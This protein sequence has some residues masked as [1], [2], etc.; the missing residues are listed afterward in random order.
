MGFTPLKNSNGSLNASAVLELTTAVGAVYWNRRDAAATLLGIVGG[1][2]VR[3]WNFDQASW[4]PSWALLQQG[5]QLVVVL[6]GTTSDVHF[7][8]DVVGCYATPYG[9]FPC[10]VHSF[11]NSVWQ[12]LRT[13][14][15]QNMP[16]GFE[17]M[18][19]TFVGHSFGAAVAFLGACDWQRSFSA[20]LV[21]YLGVAKPKPLT[22]GYTGGL[23]ASRFFVSTNFDCVSNLP[24]NDIVLSVLDALSAWRYSVPVD[25]THY[26]PGYRYQSDGIL[27]LEPGNQ[28]DITPSVGDLALTLAYHPIRNYM[29]AAEYNWQNVVG[30]GRDAAIVT[31]SQNIRAQAA[32]QNTNV[33]I[34]ARRFVDVAQQNRDMF[35]APSGGPLTPDNLPFVND[36]SGIVLGRA[37][38]NGIFPGI[39]GVTSMAQKITL[40]YHDSLAGF[41]ESHIIPTQGT[42]QAMLALA[43]TYVVLRMQCSG[44]QTTLDWIRFSTVGATRKV[45]GFTPVDLGA[46]VP[47]T[48]TFGGGGHAGIQSSDFGATSLLL[49][50]VAA[51]GSFAHWFFRGIPD[52]VVTDGGQ[53]TNAGGY[54]QAI[55]NLGTYLAQNGFSWPGTGKQA[56]MGTALSGMAQVA[57]SGQ[58]TLTFGANIFNGVAPLT[59]VRIRI[60]GQNQRPT[61]NGTFTVTVQSANT[62]YTRDTIWLPPTPTVTGIAWLMNSGGGTIQ[63]LSIER[64][65]ERR[66]GRP[67]GLYRGRSRNRVNF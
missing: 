18:P 65:V 24:P 60:S 38:S 48:G 47:T 53:Y 10:F 8:G 52:S 57:G 35:R 22:A 7:Y 26:T 50:K 36:S 16:I 43:N 30:S 29:Q 12:S 17:T 59:K 58:V 55:T 11:F 2:S 56:G 1:G 14:I 15:V 9:S 33:N 62:C 3:V 54:T 27:R 45:V 32:A 19:I 44:Q 61:M 42:T 66:V 28:W 67:F 23:P 6:A 21:E 51:D 39:S 4:P 41:S 40:F 49:R 37:A 5:T 34:D 31:L 64:V 13:S 63:S 20:P 46:N 25:W